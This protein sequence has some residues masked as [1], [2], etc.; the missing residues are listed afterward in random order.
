MLKL[1]FEIIVGATKKGMQ[2]TGVNE[3]PQRAMLSARQEAS[4]DCGKLRSRFGRVSK[5]ES[6]WKIME[7]IH[8]VKLNRIFQLTTLYFSNLFLADRRQEKIG[9]LK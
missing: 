3:M 9:F 6:R 1:L 2:S 7:Q 5:D 8:C 4:P